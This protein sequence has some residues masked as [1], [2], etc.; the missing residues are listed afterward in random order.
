MP[1]SSVLASGD[2]DWMGHIMVEKSD[3]AALPSLCAGATPQTVFFID[4]VEREACIQGYWGSTRVAKY[5]DGDEYGYGLAAA[6]SVQFSYLKISRLQDPIYSPYSNSLLT[7]HNNNTIVVYNNFLSSLT[8]SEDGRTITF[9]GNP[10]ILV[11]FEK[12]NARPVLQL[13]ENGRWVAFGSKDYGYGIINASQSNMPKQVVWRKTVGESD[14]SLPVLAVSNDGKSLVTYD[15]KH[16][17]SA[18]KVDDCVT[19]VVDR[20]L[21]SD[22]GRC[23]QSLES[24]GVVVD[25]VDHPREGAFTES[26]WKFIFYGYSGQKLVRVSITSRLAPPMYYSMPYIALGDSYTSGEGETSDDAYL[27]ATNQPHEKCHVSTRSYP[28]VVGH[29]WMIMPQSVACSGAV[30]DD[31]LGTGNYVGQGGRLGSSG[32]GYNQLE[33]RQKQQ[34]ALTQVIPGRLPQIE[35][36]RHRKPLVVS[37]GIG[38]NDVGL[39]G[40]LQSCLG[41]STCD[42]AKPGAMR[43]KVEKEVSEQYSR[44]V[45]LFTSLQSGAPGVAVLAVGYPLPVAERGA[46]HSAIAPLLNSTE[47]EFM[48][49]V[50][51]LLNQTMY[52]AATNTGVR[53]V[54]LETAYGENALCYQTDTPAMNAIRT[55]DDMGVLGINFIG[56]ESFHPTP[57]GHELAAGRILQSFPVFPHGAARC[58]S[59]CSMSDEWQRRSDYW[60]NVDDGQFVPKIVSWPSFTAPRLITNAVAPIFVDPGVFLPGSMV[61]VE[62]HSEV[63]H[64]GDLP[65][66]ADGSVNGEVRIPGDIAGRHT[67]FVIGTTISGEQIELYAD[68]DISSGDVLLKDGAS[69]VGSP[70]ILGDISVVT[71]G[72]V[73]KDAAVTHKP[74]STSGTMVIAAGVGAVILLI[75]AMTTW[76]RRH[77]GNKKV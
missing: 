64:L 73:D 50:I 70:E 52:R 27:Y 77:R 32:L 76:L 47:R 66:A 40:K 9:K 48:V 2:V 34:E 43:A 10:T 69:G 46:C 22:G 54:D 67:L 16:G 58:V 53:Y 5:R 31:I 3:A 18:Y 41:V 28:Y 49:E 44:Y 4:G 17:F 37:V 30:M 26:G 39:V 23:R 21:S 51:H 14:A 60:D 59:G 55:G 6:F 74:S 62:L 19:P 15:T 56:A 61:R 7:V 29:A 12:S 42:W 63:R 20:R 25:G 24:V 45:A 36:V 57:Y 13:S 35:F 75:V 71:G 33:I 38:G 72:G 68:V 1:V 8:T 11:Q 65:V